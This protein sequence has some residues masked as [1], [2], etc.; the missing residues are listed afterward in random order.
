MLKKLDKIIFLKLYNFA[1]NHR[2]I[3]KAVVFISKLSSKLFAAIY[4]AAIIYLI[5]GGRTLRSL[6]LIPALFYFLA[7]LIPYFYNRNRPFVRYNIK[8]LVKQRKDHSFPSTHT[9]SS[10]II[11]LALLN[12][13]FEIGIIM[14]FAALLTAFSRIMTGVHYPS[15]ILGSWLIAVALHLGGLY[16]IV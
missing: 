9:G 6:I 3:S 11:A 7:K 15:D 10:L 2:R 5:Y 1:I 8:V 4:F 16:F 13:N 12:I 14:V